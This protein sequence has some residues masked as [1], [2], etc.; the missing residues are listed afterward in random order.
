MLLST[1][2]LLQRK[3]YGFLFKYSVVD[4]NTMQC[5]VFHANFKTALK[6]TQYVNLVH[7]I[8]SDQKH[9]YTTRYVASESKALLFRYT[10]IYQ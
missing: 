4:D 6:T 8:K 5:D 7:L 9:I 10:N 2:V 3:H 1:D